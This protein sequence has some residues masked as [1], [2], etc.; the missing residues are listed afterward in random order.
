[1]AIR[2]RFQF[3]LRT[4]LLLVFVWS[5]LASYIGAYYR[6]SRRGVEEAADYGLEGCFLYVPTDRAMETQDLTEHYR[7]MRFFAPASWIDQ[8]IFGGPPPIRGIIFELSRIKGSELFLSQINSSNP[9]HF[10]Q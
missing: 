1:M 3:S 4:L 6:L 5:L 8:H 2:W 10:P 7:R 9:S